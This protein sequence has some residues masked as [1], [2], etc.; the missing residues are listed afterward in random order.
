[1]QDRRVESTVDDRHHAAARLNLPGRD[2]GLALFGQLPG[3]FAI[4]ATD[5]KRQRAEAE[6]LEMPGLKLTPAQASRLWDLGVDAT[7][8]MLE[9]MVEAGLLFRTKDGAYLLLS[10]R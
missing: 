1:M 2:P 6:Y 5:G 9:A 7:T 3:L 10:A 4:L 8:E